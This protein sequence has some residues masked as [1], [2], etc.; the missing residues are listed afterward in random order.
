[1]V[2][3]SKEYAEFAGDSVVTAGADDEASEEDCLVFGYADVFDGH[4][5]KR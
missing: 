5:G 2:K 4:R 3:K 1:V